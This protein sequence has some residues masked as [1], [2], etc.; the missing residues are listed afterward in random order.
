MPVVSEQFLQ[1][2]EQ[3]ADAVR[4]EAASRGTAPSV[5]RTPGVCGGEARVRDTRITV[6]TLIALQRQ[7]ASEAELIENFASLTPSDLDAV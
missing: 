6:G 4:R 2:V 5:Q 3:F 7:G 1:Q